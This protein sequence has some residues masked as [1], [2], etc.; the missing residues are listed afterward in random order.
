RVAAAI[1]GAGCMPPTYSL[2][3]DYFPEAAARTRALAIYMLA[4]S[5]ALLVSF[6]AGGWVNERYGWRIAFFASGAPGVINALLTRITI[7]EPRAGRGPV[8]DA[9]PRVP[10]MADVL[11]TLWHQRSLRHLCIGLILVYTMGGGLAPWYAA[12]LMRSHAMRTSELGV[13]LG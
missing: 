12:F 4:S 6:T 8:R 11:G 9:R 1:W 3:G 13:W 5:V 2:V 7:V 10:R